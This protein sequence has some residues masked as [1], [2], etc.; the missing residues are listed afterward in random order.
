VTRSE[1]P[2]ELAVA[3]PEDELVEDWPVAAGVEVDELDELEFDELD[4]LDP[5]PTKN[6]SRGRTSRADRFMPS[7]Y[8]RVG[9]F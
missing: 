5:Q 8:S 6:S 1:P 4:E 3:P 2:P 9:E 7:A